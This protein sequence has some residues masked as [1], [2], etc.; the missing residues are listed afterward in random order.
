M[1][2]RLPNIATV[3]YRQIY[4]WNKLQTES[5][6]SI[7]DLRWRKSIPSHRVLSLIEKAG[8]AIYPRWFLNQG[9]PQ[10]DRFLPLV[11]LSTSK[12]W[13]M[14]VKTPAR[15]EVLIAHLTANS[16]RHPL[17]RLQLPWCLVR[18]TG[19]RFDHNIP[20][21]GQRSS[22]NRNSGIPMDTYSISSWNESTEGKRFATGAITC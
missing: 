22:P 1:W 10:T 7:G 5:H 11:F 8:F 3:F 14:E 13:T 6:K 18:N 21:Q 16:G 12:R 9:G 19:L 2:G 15:L 20:G 17:L 4:G